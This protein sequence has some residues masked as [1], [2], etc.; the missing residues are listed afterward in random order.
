MILYLSMIDTPKEQVKFELLYREY[1]DLM[2]YTANR[3]LNNSQDAEDVMQQAF[4]S[5][6][7]NLKKIS[8]IKCPKTRSYIVIIVERKAIDLL[9]LRYRMS[10]AELNED[11]FR[12]EIPLPGDNGLADA[13][14]CLPVHYRDVLLLKYDN[15]FSTREIGKMLGITES[16]VR[17]LIGRAKEALKR[18]MEKEG[19][20]F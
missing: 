17:K 18:Q 11:T 13:M 8:D 12:K 3:I 14:A 4:L 15:G 1:K 20:E 16:G 2:F 6:I 19:M 7:K 5:I 10:E 9:R